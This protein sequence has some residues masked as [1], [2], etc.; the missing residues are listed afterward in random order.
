MKTNLEALLLERTKR[1]GLDS[2]LHEQTQDKAPA[3]QDYI[4]IFMQEISPEFLKRHNQALVHLELPQTMPANHAAADYSYQLLLKNGI[5]AEKVNLVADGK[6]IYHD[7]TMPLCWDASYGRLTV[8]SDWE[9][10]RVVADYDEEPFSLI[11]YS[12]STPK[13][14]I[15]TRLVRWDDMLA[16][17]DV[18]G[19]FVLLT[20]ALL[21]TDATLN[22]ILN[23][24]AIG[25]VN[26]AVENKSTQAADTVHWANNCTE[27]NSWCVD[28]GERDFIGFCVSPRMLEKLDAACARGEVIIK[29][30]SDGRRYAGFMPGVTAII[31][32]ESK[33]EFWAIAHNSE[34]LEDDNSTGVMCCVQ[35]IIAIKKA[36][37]EGK[38]PPLKYTLRILL[39]PERYGTIAFAHHF[40]NVLHDRCIG[41]LCVDAVPASPNT[42]IGKL[43][44]APP[45][46]PF[47]GNCVWEGLWDE[48]TRNIHLTPLTVGTGDYWGG[49]SFLSDHSV[50][51]PTV[52]YLHTDRYS[53]HNSY[54]RFDYVDYAQ[55]KRATA[56]Y[57]AFMAAVTV[58][59][60]KLFENF[61]P[62]AA[63]YANGRL[64]KVA[65]TIPTRRG[66]C[67]KARLNR[68]KEIEIANIRSFADANV[69]QEAIE[70]ACQMIETFANSLTP[71]EALPADGPSIL[72][73]FDRIIPKR[74]TV[75]IPHDLARVPHERRWHPLYPQQ[76]FIM[77]RVFSSM[78][79]KRSLK[80]LIIE[81][82]W[83]HGSSW[84]E[85]TLAAF[86]ETLELICEFGYIELNRP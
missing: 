19:A 9:G 14:G 65:S 21:P 39:A 69:S 18:K 7:G 59:D 77:S 64:A 33:R 49:D 71:L 84:S 23:A 35:A 40:G 41:G 60:G 16:G 72:D 26:G 57:T 37:E 28:E 53:W 29:A 10:K 11:K 13:E 44:F 17:A 79:G 68:R 51:L 83:D 81:A 15:T 45:A 22:P 3:L 54:Q 73:T 82:E 12:V 43:F 27:T 85:D 80:E 63:A 66:T 36:L 76:T 2:L 30:E 61:L 55:F 6:T 20:K 46:I 56:V 74:L 86:M 52:T 58:C 4:D 70:R 62:T 38:I 67:A 8:L 42:A 34:P 50:G 25:L 31:P 47:Y 32:G 78:D 5:D 75:G 24:G 1:T 48:Y